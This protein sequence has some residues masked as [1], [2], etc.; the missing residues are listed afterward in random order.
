MGLVDTDLPQLNLL[1]GGL[2][3]REAG[4]MLCP[5][6]RRYVWRLSRQD[7]FVCPTCGWR[8]DS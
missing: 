8:S 3:E 7:P 6:C 1:L 2:L 5:L 4:V